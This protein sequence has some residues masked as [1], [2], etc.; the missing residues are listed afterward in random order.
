MQQKVRTALTTFGVAVGALVLLLSLS[1]G[2]GIQEAVVREFRR[3]DELRKIEVRAGYGKVEEHI[4]PAE[5]V[6][7]GDVSEAKRRRLRERLV[8]PGSRPRLSAHDAVDH[9][10]PRAKSATW[11]HVASVTP[12]YTDWGRVDPRRQGEDVETVSATARASVVCAPAHGRRMVHG[13]RRAL[14]RRERIPPLPVGM[15]SD[16]EVRSAVGRKLRLEY[17]TGASGR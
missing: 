17:R 4:P 3:H 9:R 2:V 1:I 5:L 11:P 13:R 14:R 12:L 6:V 10:T 15:A 7:K 16:D 8:Q